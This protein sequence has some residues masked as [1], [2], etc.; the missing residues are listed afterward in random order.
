LAI[1]AH[2]AWFVCL[3]NLSWVSTELSDALCRLATG[4]GFCTRSLY[5]DDEEAIFHAQR[6]ALVNSIEDVG[7]RSD[8]LDRSLV[9][10][11]PRIEPSQRRAE[12]DFWRDFEA[13]WPRILGA[14]LDAVAAG[15]KNL[16]A[17]RQSGWAWPRMA[18]FAAW[19]TAAEEAL[20]LSRGQFLKA[21][22]LNRATA[23]RVA[24]ESSPVVT[25][26]FGLVQPGGRWEG[27]TTQLHVQLSIGQDTRV[28][29]WPKAPHVL[30]GML[31][32]LA[33][34]LR[35]VGISVERI[36]IGSGNDKRDGWRII[37]NDTS[38]TG[39]SIPPQ[40]SPP[41]GPS[42]PDFGEMARELVKRLEERGARAARGASP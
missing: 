3:D 4:G 38:K 42:G 11:L 7:S 20:G 15:L 39:A 28:K 14:L 27:N 26:L 22:Q 24:L 31:K 17:V 30:S 34:N 19:A 10:E 25:A 5:T 21:Y 36:V 2:N 16:P 40:T 32:R 13:A 33:P 6:P 1:A 12:A 41:S 8:L 37:R 35:A 18:D 23:N 9:V 29:G